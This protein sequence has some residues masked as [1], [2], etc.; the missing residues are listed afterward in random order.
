MVHDTHDVLARPSV[1]VVPAAHGWHTRS[2]VGVRSRMMYDPLVHT[3]AWE[4][5][6]SDVY[7]G[8]VLW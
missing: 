5:I 8:A 1:S 7:V 3:V 4:H 6:A 2:L